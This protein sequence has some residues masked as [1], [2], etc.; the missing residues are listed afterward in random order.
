MWVLPES[1]VGS[2]LRTW[3]WLKSGLC[4]TPLDPSQSESL[5]P[6]SSSRP[7]WVYNWTGMRRSRTMG[8]TSG[9]SYRTLSTMIGAINGAPVRGR[10]APRQGRNQTYSDVNSPFPL[11]KKEKN[12]GQGIT[13]SYISLHYV[14]V[15]DTAIPPCQNHECDSETV[16]PECEV[17]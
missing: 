7:R 2:C 11:R 1:L 13:W 10:V 15:I 12:F 8:G 14:Q 6:C 16:D 17:R 4:R 3:A 5:I 9:W